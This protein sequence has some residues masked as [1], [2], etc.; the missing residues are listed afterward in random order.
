MQTHAYCTDNTHS[1]S[2]LRE[3]AGLHRERP[4]VKP[5]AAVSPHPQL[6]AEGDILS[7]GAGCV[8]PRQ[9]RSRHGGLV[10]TTPP[11]NRSSKQPAPE[12]RSLSVCRTA[13]LS[14][15]CE[16]KMDERHG[17]SSAGLCPPPTSH[18]SAVLAAPDLLK[19]ALFS[20]TSL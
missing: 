6:N 8:E 16:C 5:P 18:T 13:A 19:E 1:P 9:R 15:C 11:R 17:E 7:L 4:V 2:H 3:H 14:V 20:C 10:G 12:R